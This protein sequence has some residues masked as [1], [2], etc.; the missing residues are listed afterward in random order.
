[1]HDLLVV[2][3]ADDG[4]EGTDKFGGVGLGVAAAAL[5]LDEEWLAS[6]RLQDQMDVLLGLVDLEE[7][8]R[9]IA[10]DLPK[11]PDVVDHGPLSLPDK[12]LRD[13]GRFRRVWPCKQISQRR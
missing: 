9:P 3:V 8:N 4:Q 13:C 2:A 12:D 11:D 5:D 7:S 6:D 1:M 10:A